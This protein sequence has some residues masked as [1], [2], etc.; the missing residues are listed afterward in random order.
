MDFPATQ[1]GGGG[2]AT[3]T[4]THTLTSNFFFS[5]CFCFND[6]LMDQTS[7]PFQIAKNKHTN[8]V[9]YDE[10]CCLLVKHQ[11]FPVE[12]AV[13]LRVLQIEYREEN[14]TN[15]SLFNS[16]F[17][18]TISKSNTQQ[19]TRFSLVCVCCF[20]LKTDANTTIKTH[21]AFS[22]TQTSNDCL[23][24]AFLL[25]CNALGPKYQR[26]RCLTHQNAIQRLVLVTNVKINRFF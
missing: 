13:L 20:L 25:P 5:F 6:L 8:S 22:N 17:T 18:R 24:P 7:F 9:Y 12:P 10:K 14:E 26:W 1:I 2:G 15:R 11:V 21:Q 3:H 19:Y 23:W 16:S 4:H